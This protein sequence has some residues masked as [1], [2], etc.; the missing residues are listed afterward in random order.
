MPIGSFFYENNVACWI[1]NRDTLQIVDVNNKSLSI[2]GY[3][4]AE[5]RGSV[6]V[7]DLVPR[8]YER[9]FHKQLSGKVPEKPTVFLQVRRDGSLFEAII[10]TQPV[11]LNGFSC[12]YVMV[13][14]GWQV[15]PD[16]PGKAD[17]SNEERLVKQRFVQRANANL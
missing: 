17:R 14:E 4:D 3:T 12:A 2:Y 15:I 16:E 1:Y 11:R 6:R 10:I 9:V 13:V 8:Q 7:S 5:F